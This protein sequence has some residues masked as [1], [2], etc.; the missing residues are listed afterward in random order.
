MIKTEYIRNLNCN[1][2]RVLL[3]NQPDQKKYQYCILD[4]G[5]MKYLLRCSYKN[6]DGE[7]Y[8]YYD[9]SSTQSVRQMFSEKCIRRDWM[10]DF[11]WSMQKLRLELNRFLLDERNIVWN[12]AHI[13]QDLEKNDF[14]YLY[15]PYYGQEGKLEEGFDKLLEFWVERIDYADE[16]LV[17]FI[18]HAYEQY[19][20]AGQS[21]LEKQIFDDFKK[22]DEKQ[23]QPIIKADNLTAQSEAG[24]DMLPPEDVYAGKL[25]AHEEQST[26]K[27]G[28]RFFFEERKRKQEQRNS[29]REE[30]RKMINGY[31]VCEESEY[32]KKTKTNVE[33]EEEFGKTIYIEEKEE[34]LQGLYTERG[35]LVIR[36]EKFPFVLG[37]RREDAD[38]V[39]SDYASSRV[40]AR[41]I[42]ENAE[43]YIEDLNSTNGTFK[44]GLRLQPYEK[45]R[46]EP[47]DVLRFGKSTFVYK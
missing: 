21:Y 30:M 7:T 8:L 32:G 29:Y 33:K 20:Q 5:G 36:L 35:E 9:I 39:L 22:V 2:V 41:F 23:T 47:E 44:N 26:Q 16:A 46:L 42:Q 27:R 38:Y 13:F 18:Y 25:E 37:K 28:I 34:T 14:L 45:R 17:E 4:R 40:H 31:A 1:F 11:F 10:K 15:I 12:P 43:I 19:M 3:E 6:I 24:E